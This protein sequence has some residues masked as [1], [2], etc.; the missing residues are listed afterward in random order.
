MQLEHPRELLKI[1]RVAAALLEEG[2]RL[3]RFDSFA[4]EGTRLDGTQRSELDPGQHA[5]AIGPLERGRQA[6][7]QSGA[8]DQPTAIR[9]AAAGGRR[10]SAP[11]S[12]T[13]AESAQWTSS[14][15]STSGARL[16]EPHQDL[17]DR[18]MAAIA[19]V[20]ERHPAVVGER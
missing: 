19:L 6:V 17:A 18:A 7:W 11:S 13:D 10:S 3:D 5:L 14:S 16:G 15:T 20:L 9:T 12:S 1:E 8:D 4:E 2:G